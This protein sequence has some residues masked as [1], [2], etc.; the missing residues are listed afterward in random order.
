MMILRG[1]K[2]RLDAVTFSPDGRAIAAASWQQ[3][4]LWKEWASTFEPTTALAKQYVSAIRYHP[5]G[6][7]LLV[8]GGLTPW[9]WYPQA[10]E[11]SPLR[12]EEDTFGQFADLTSDGEFVLICGTNTR[13]ERP[14][15]ILCRSTASPDELHWSLNSSRRIESAPLFLSDGEHF[16]VLEYHHDRTTYTNSRYEFV[17]RSCQT[18]V[19]TEIVPA[20]CDELLKPALSPD[21]RQLAGMRTNSFYV[22][23][24]SALD[25]APLRVPAGGRKHFT[26]LAFH[27][28]G[29]FLAAT[30]NDATVKLYDTSN[31]ALATT[32]TWDIGRMRSVAFSPDGTLAAA[33]SDT[34]RVVVWDVDV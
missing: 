13:R 17:L 18:G 25:R 34:G 3:V 24:T 23:D 30:S 10:D 9:I 1:A 16:L 19:T 2:E 20:G 14:G 32:Y 31:W 6:E 4:Q 28:S 21:S 5:A 26:S 27:P 15:S 11:C 8:S 7:K 29:R 33:G 12:G 22:F